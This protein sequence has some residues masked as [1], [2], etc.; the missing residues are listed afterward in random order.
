MG[1]RQN[2]S[3]CQDT[4]SAVHEVYGIFRSVLIHKL[5]DAASNFLVF[6]VFDIREQVNKF[7]L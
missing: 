2:S 3:N 7:H 4:S 5:K 1:I 6:F